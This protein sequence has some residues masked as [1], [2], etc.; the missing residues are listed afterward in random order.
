MPGS[1]HYLGEAV[2]F[3]TRA[4]S[5][6]ETDALIK[7]FSSKGYRVIDERIKPKGEYAWTG[8]HIHVEWTPQVK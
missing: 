8:P 4:H 7:L 2:D 3:P 5:N 6:A 1:K